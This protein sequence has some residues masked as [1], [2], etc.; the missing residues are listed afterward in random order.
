MSILLTGFEPFDDRI[1]ASQALVESLRDDPPGTIPDFG[2]LVHC[3]IMPVDT[4]RIGD[5]LADA[6]EECNPRF[7]VMTGQAAGRNMLTLERVATN[8]RDFDKPD[9]YGNQVRGETII[10]DGPVGYWSTLPDPEGLTAAL[11]D[12]GIPTALSNHGGNHLCNQI[13]YLALH[14]ATGNAPGMD[15][16]FIHIP[17]L[18]EQVQRYHHRAPFMPLNMARDAMTII[19]GGLLRLLP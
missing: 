4:D 13:L 9:S 2:R 11:N 12:A 6:I 5:A 16:G 1:N 15:A 3:R 8:L 19:I 10:P 7:C 18:P 17:V 14:H